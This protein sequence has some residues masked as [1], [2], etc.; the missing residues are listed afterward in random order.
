MYVI[1]AAGT[2]VFVNTES[3]LNDKELH[4]FIWKLKHD[5]EF[6]KQDQYILEYVMAD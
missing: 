2:I 5:I 4:S 1:S 3:F 6:A